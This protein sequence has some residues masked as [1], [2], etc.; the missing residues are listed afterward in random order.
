MAANKCVTGQLLLANNEVCDYILC[1]GYSLPLPGTEQLYVLLHRTQIPHEYW[2]RENNNVLNPKPARTIN[3]Q[4]RWL[5]LACSWSPP[6]VAW[7]FLLPQYPH[8]QACELQDHA[9]F[10]FI[11]CSNICSQGLSILHAIGNCYP[12]LHPATSKPQ[13]SY[14]YVSIYNL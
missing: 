5:T 12:S 1:N 9:R 3:W 11:T 13:I 14:L 6:W 7:P 10:N 2:E 4:V 8:G